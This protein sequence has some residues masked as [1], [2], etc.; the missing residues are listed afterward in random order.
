VTHTPFAL[1]WRLQSPDLRTMRQKP[2]NTISCCGAPLP[3]TGTSVRL[4]KD[5]ARRR[6]NRRRC[7]TRDLSTSTSISQHLRKLCRPW[8]WL[9]LSGARGPRRTATLHLLD[10]ARMSGVVACPHPQQAM[11]RRS[12]ERNARGLLKLMSYN[13]DLSGGT[14][15]MGRKEAL[16]STGGGTSSASKKHIKEI[17]TSGRFFMKGI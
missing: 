10:L 14:V 17:S 4:Q 2:S 16:T 6:L 7:H 11:A 9:T 13:L 5:L 3:T 8:P 15:A 12:A 1:P